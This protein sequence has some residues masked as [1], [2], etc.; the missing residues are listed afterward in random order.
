MLWVFFIPHEKSLPE[1]KGISEKSRGKRGRESELVPD[2]PVHSDPAIPE[3]VDLPRTFHWWESG[4]KSGG[5]KIQPFASFLFLSTVMESH[6]AWDRPYLLSWYWLNW[7]PC[8]VV[9]PTLDTAIHHWTR[10][11]LC[12]QEA[13]SPVSSQCSPLGFYPDSKPLIFKTWT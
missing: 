6:I 2:P 1:T 12:S 7:I 13:P 5:L 10:H 4:S 8:S 11:G 3:A 9:G